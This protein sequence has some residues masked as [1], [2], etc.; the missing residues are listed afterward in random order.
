MTHRGI[1]TIV[2]ILAQSNVVEVV[3]PSMDPVHMGVLIL[4]L[5]PLTVLVRILPYKEGFFTKHCYYVFLMMFILFTSIWKPFYYQNKLTFWKIRYSLIICSLFVNYYVQY[6]VHVIS[7]RSTVLKAKVIYVLF[8]SE[9]VV[10]VFCFARVFKHILWNITL[11][12]S[13]INQFW[14]INLIKFT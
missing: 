8:L 7:F 5:S 13:N 2:P 3:T 11:S 9:Y 6:V 1:Q 10:V 14:F 4:T 12:L